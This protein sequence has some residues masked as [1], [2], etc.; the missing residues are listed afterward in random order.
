MAGR[1][2]RWAEQNRRRGELKAA[3]R[4]LNVPKR[5]PLQTAEARARELRNRETRDRLMLAKV[6]RQSERIRADLVE[7]GIL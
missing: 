3:D 6:T 2:M 7:A 1:P 5:S 4:E